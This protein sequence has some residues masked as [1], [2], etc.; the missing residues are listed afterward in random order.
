MIVTAESDETSYGEKKSA[1]IV[2][3]SLALYAILI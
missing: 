1:K 3:G 2:R